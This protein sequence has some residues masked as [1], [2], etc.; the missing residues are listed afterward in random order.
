MKL[1][2]LV[3]FSIPIL[4]FH[5]KKEDDVT[6]AH[7]PITEEEVIYANENVCIEHYFKGVARDSATMQPLPAGLVLEIFFPSTCG[8]S[9]RDTLD[10]NG[11][12]LLYSGKLINKL[13][14]CS[15]IKQPKV[16]LWD[17]DSILGSTWMLDTLIARD[18]IDVDLIF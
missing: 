18:T 8:C 7:S 12:Y 1:K 16:Q 11:N 13:V 2:Y 6:V 4:L 9:G 3:F 10:S 15:T 5:C 14:I 17:G